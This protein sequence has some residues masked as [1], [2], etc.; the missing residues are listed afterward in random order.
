MEDAG[1]DDRS[2]GQWV[3]ESDRSAMLVKE[4]VRRVVALFVMQCT[5]GT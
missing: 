5:D 4:S 3:Q 1:S 2:S